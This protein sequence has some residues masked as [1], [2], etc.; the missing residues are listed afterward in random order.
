MNH[1][2]TFTRITSL[3]LLISAAAISPAMRALSEFISAG[4]V[5]PIPAAVGD[6]AKH[7][8]LDTIAAMVSGAVLPPGQLA[9]L[10]LGVPQ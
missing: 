1:S 6:K 9:L 3:A 7:H 10:T 8:L 4:S 5:V 2:N